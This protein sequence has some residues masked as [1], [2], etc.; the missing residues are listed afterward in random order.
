M[1]PVPAETLTSYYTDDQLA[2][3]KG[4]TL[5]TLRN[6]VRN[7]RAT[8]L[9]PSIR[10]KPRVRLWSKAG[11]REWLMKAWAGDVD[12][13][14]RLIDLGEATAPWPDGTVLAA[15]GAPHN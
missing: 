10:P 7:A 1:H 11:T 12:A 14:Q 9:P 6:Y 2:A 3:I 15:G 4:V 5:G 13:V 8:D